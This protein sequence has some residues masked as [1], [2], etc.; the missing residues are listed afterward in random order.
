MIT[1]MTGYGDAESTCD[2]VDYVVE[3]RSVNH[4]YFK[5]AIKVPEF[6]QRFESEIEGLLRGRLLRGSINYL[7]RA[8]PAVGAVDTQINTA[9]LRSYVEKLAPLTATPGVVLDVAA[10]LSTTGAFTPPQIDADGRQRVWETIQTLT[11]EAVDKLLVMR[12]E[13]GRALH[14]DLVEQ[15]SELRRLSEVTEIRAPL[16]IKEYQQRLHTRIQQ[17][18]ADSQLDADES[19]LLRECAVFAERC[20]IT[21]ELIRVR[22]HLDQFAK[23]CSSKERAGRKLDFV[24]QEMLREV[25]TI[26]SK[27]NDAEIARSVVEMKACVDR[28]KEQVQNVE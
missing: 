17:L 2:Q 18:L 19:S 14:K 3:I 28:I 7:L 20:D 26:G 24:A 1:S 4:R 5:S 13:E 21:E 23:L 22:S 15:G 25:N 9:V 27:A 16:V 10:L 6:L 11:I 8:R 12:A